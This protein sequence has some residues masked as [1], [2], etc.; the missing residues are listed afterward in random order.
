MPRKALVPGK[1]GN[2]SDPGVDHS[3]HKNGFVKA[4][5]VRLNY[6]DWGGTGPALILVHGGLDNAHTF[7][8][9][10]PEF[11]DRFHVLAHTRRANGRSEEKGPY[12]FA[13]LTEDLRGL[14]DAL[15]VNR[16][17]LAGY[18]MGGGEVTGMASTY[19]DRVDRVVYLDSAWETTDPAHVPLFNELHFRSQGLHEYLRSY[20]RWK[21]PPTAMRSL[22]AFREYFWGPL[23]RV[24]VEGLEGN[25]LDRV[26]VRPDGTVQLRRRM[27][28]RAMEWLVTCLLKGGRQDFSKVRAPA[29]AIVAKTF[30]SAERGVPHPAGWNLAWERKFAAFKE[31]SLRRIRGDLPSLTVVRVPGDHVGF[32][33]AAH[34]RVVGAMQQFFRADTGMP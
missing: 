23:P 30:L 22:R 25:L 21:P 14:M 19:P 32:L 2:R 1:S 6:L 3:P 17:N 20:S 34:R 31:A 15:R 27:S 11:T 24:V 33:Y 29:L 12:N 5:G 16:A 13:T 7:D 9:L 18:S 4:N 10:A 8:D 26:I 28:P